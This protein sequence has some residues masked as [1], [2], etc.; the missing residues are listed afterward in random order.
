M[1]TVVVYNTFSILFMA[2]LLDEK[3]DLEIQSAFSSDQTAQNS[4]D[5]SLKK[6]FFK[7]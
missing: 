5:D 6:T 7:S 1:L 4:R 2:Y 3:F